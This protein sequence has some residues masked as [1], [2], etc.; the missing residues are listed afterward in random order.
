[1]SISSSS[2]KHPKFIPEH[3]KFA[4]ASLTPR[5]SPS[6]P[7]EHLKF[8]PQTPCFQS[9]S[10]PSSPLEHPK[11]I[12]EHLKSPHSPPDGQTNSSDVFGTFFSSRKSARTWIFPPQ[13]SKLLLPAAAF[14]GVN[15]HLLLKT[16]HLISRLNWLL[17][18]TQD[19]QI[20]KPDPL[21]KHRA[22]GATLLKY[23]P[24][25]ERGAV[26]NQEYLHIL[27]NGRKQTTANRAV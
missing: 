15:Y 14:P 17:F 7:L 4:R 26:D 18:H 22:L 21:L 9:S 24:F 2:L 1:M 10:I 27:H 16:R 13:T 11:F 19:H 5:A 6:S 3:P 25:G 12:L 20:L 23:S 8:L